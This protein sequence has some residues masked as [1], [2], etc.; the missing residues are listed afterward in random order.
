MRLVR[1]FFFL[2]FLFSLVIT[3]VSAVSFD[4]TNFVS[5]DGSVVVNVSEWLF[6]ASEINIGSDYV[7]FVSLGCNSSGYVFGTKNF[8][9][10][11]TY[12]LDDLFACGAVFSATEIFTEDSINDFSVY[13]LSD[14]NSSV[15]ENFENDFYYSVFDITNP[16]NALDDNPSTY[17]SVGSGASTMYFYNKFDI[18]SDGTD[19]NAPFYAVTFNHTWNDAGFTGTST[20][21]F[22]YL[23]SS[24]SWVSVG[25]HDVNTG[26]SYS[27]AVNDWVYGLRLRQIP[28]SCSVCSGLRLN[29]ISINGYN[30]TQRADITTTGSLS[31]EFPPEDY[32]ISYYFTNGYF[33]TTESKDYKSGIT[34]LTSVNH[35]D[36]SLTLY[37][38]YNSGFVSSSC[39]YDGYESS[40]ALEHFFVT[41]HTQNDLRCYGGGYNGTPYDT[42]T[43]TSYPYSFVYNISK[44]PAVN[45]TIRTEANNSLITELVTMEFVSNTTA[46]TNTTTTGTFYDDSIPTGAYTITFSSA[47]F[48]SRQYQATFNEFT[49]QEL[50][51]YLVPTGSPNTVFT[52][53]DRD[54]SNLLEDVILTVEANVDGVWTV[55][56]VL[57]SDITGKAQFDYVASKAYRFTASKTGY[58]SKTWELNP[59]LFSS[60][61]INMVKDVDEAETGA[62]TGVS[63]RI[64]PSTYYNGAANN[65]SILFANP[66]GNFLSYGYNVTFNGLTNTTSGANVYGSTLTTTINVYNA[67][68][69]DVVTLKY[70]YVLADGT[71][72]DFTKTYSLAVDADGS[73]LKNLGQD[74][75]LGLFE[76]LLIMTVITIVVAGVVAVFS[77]EIAGGVTA[78]FIWGFF[79]WTGFVSYWVVIPSLV[80]LTILVMWRSSR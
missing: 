50:N 74:Y 2:F 76:R 70:Y 11:G 45:I 61:V 3:S 15:P 14:F 21:T 75:G 44:V 12:Q 69:N 10:A 17:A 31:F 57:S 7:D 79:V 13:L 72:H 8:T 58:T 73:W 6:D 40:S 37:D 64:T 42:S 25:S 9:S 18:D 28:T 27:Y 26:G 52:F 53:K 56:E 34:D 60:Y 77:N 30:F 24:G 54:T 43:I 62:L 59:I 38:L 63:I 46:F 20:V 5:I 1:F 19:N 35:S 80:F 48:T 36:T 51:A 67:S 66:R 41:Q 22:E 47:N 4:D 39:Y 49:Y 23:N 32:N 71:R 65:V 68:I 29:E 55:V 33:N 78:M 16:S